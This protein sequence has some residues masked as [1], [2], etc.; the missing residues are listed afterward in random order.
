[1][2]ARISAVVRSGWIVVVAGALAATVYGCSDDVD[3]TPGGTGGTGAAGGTGGVG[4]VGGIGGGGG[5]PP[6]ACQP[7]AEV[8]DPWEVTFRPYTLG[9][10]D[11]VDDALLEI[12]GSDGT[13]LASGTSDANGEIA[14]SV[15]TGGTPI[16]G[17]FTAAKTGYL[18]T[19]FRIQGGLG[20]F[21]TWRT[22]MITEASADEGVPD[23]WPSETRDPNA[24]F[25]LTSTYDCNKGSE[26]WGLPGATVS[27]EP[28]GLPVKYLLPSSSVGSQLTATTR[29]GGTITANV[30]AGDHTIT[31]TLDGVETTYE[32]PIEAGFWESIILYPKADPPDCHPADMSGFTPN[33]KPSGGL[34]QGLCTDQQADDLLAACWGGMSNELSCNNWKNDGANAACL[35]C[36]IV[37]YDDPIWNAVVFFESFGFY[38]RAYGSCISAFEGDLSDQSCGAKLQAAWDCAGNACDEGCPVVAA[39]GDLDSSRFNTCFFDALEGE[40]SSLWT[41][42]ETCLEALTGDGD[43]IDQCVWEYEN[44]S[45]PVLARRYVKLICG[46]GSA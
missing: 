10:G 14:L 34:A 43:P 29:Q 37:D 8:P 32:R 36:A 12:H 30:Q 4:G 31:V 5:A 23:E 42:A 2:N 17:Y 20:W 9:T 1:M 25:V 26:V 18:T 33:W 28:G 46:D 11:P 24:A 21:A 41:E 6:A 35:A 16:D 22:M 27:L 3:T 40:C 19:R 38:D 39:S 44:E 45:W 15:A 7:P 13:V